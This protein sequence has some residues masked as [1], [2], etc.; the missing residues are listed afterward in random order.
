M[1]RTCGRIP[2]P[3]RLDHLGVALVA[4][5][6]VF[7]SG[8]G[9]RHRESPDAGT[10]ASS[11]LVLAPGMAS[12]GILHQWNFDEARDWHDSPFGPLEKAPAKVLDLAGGWDLT[13]VGLTAT[14]WVSGREFMAVQMPGGAAHLDAGRDLA[15]EL[16]GTASLAFWIRTTQK[17]GL[18][19]WEAPG[20]AGAANERHRDGIQWGW[21]DREGRLIL[22]ADKDTLACTPT[23]VSDGAWHFVVL[24]RDA[25]TGAGQVYL[26]GARV[27]SRTGPKG[28]R[29]LAFR[30]LGQIEGV[31][32]A[33]GALSG[34]LDKVTVFNRVLP[35]GEVNSFMANHAPKAWDCATEISSDRPCVT[36]SVLAQAY[37]AENDA[38]A[39]RAWTQPA[40]GTATHNG[41]GSF[42]YSAAPGFAGE[43]RF[44]VVIQD[45]QG[46]FHQAALKVTVVNETSGGCVPTV[47][48]VGLAELTAGGSVI[49]QPGWRVPRIADW[50]GDGKPDLLVGAGGH[51]WF[52]RNTGTSAVHSFAAGVKVQAAGADV[53]SGDGICPIALADMT[54][55]GVSDLIVSDAARKLQVYGNTAHKGQ[56]VALAAPVAVKQ[57]DG[58]DLVLP[59]RRFDIGD[60][61]GDGKPD[62]I[63][64]AGSGDVRLFIGEG[65]AAPRYSDSRVLFSGSYNLYPR[66]CDLNGNGQADLV[67][68]VNWGG[69]AYWLDVGVQGLAKAGDLAIANAAG[70][71]DSLRSADGAAVD[72][73]DLDGDGVPDLVAGGHA[74][75]RIQIACGRRRTVLDYLVRIEAI[76]N[77]HPDDLGTALSADD[78]ALLGKIDEANRGIVSLIQN[79]SPA[80]REAVYTALA[81][82]VRKYP[83][84]KYQKLDAKKFHHVPGIVLQNWVLLTHARPDTAVHRRDVAEVMGLTGIVRDI[85]LESSLALG[86][87]G[88]LD[89]AQLGSVR[90]MM[91]HQPRPLFPDS[92]ITFDQLFGDGR[93]GFI[94]TPDSTKNTFG[95]G[96]GMANEWAR[97]LTEAIE[98]ASGKGAADG[99][100]FTFVMGHEVTHSMDGYVSSRANKDLRRRWGHMLCHAAGPDVVAGSNGWMDWEATKKHFQ[101]AGF[102]SPP[103]QT[104]EQAW[105]TYWE[106]G[107]GSKFRHTS[108]MRGGI[109]WFL[110]S[111]QESLA[112]QANHHWASG[113]GRLVGALAR[114]RRGVA[115]GNLPEKANMTEVVDFIDYLSVGMNRVALPKTT[116][117]TAPEKRV[118][119][120]IHLADLERDDL[121]RITRL[122]VDG[123][124]FELK[125]DAGGTVT[126]VRHASVPR[127]S[128]TSRA[129]SRGWVT[130]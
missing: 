111:P 7:G 84:L 2:S 57:P 45:G 122:A 9:C 92:V 62:L 115:T 71:P 42:T 125:L 41:D 66:F 87:N 5:V 21:L 25:A 51:V 56:A 94:W 65:S 91:R 85:Y 17:G 19:A 78:N 23:P 110:G 12:D 68:G 80:T 86:D 72:L 48:F 120:T 82:H 40:H 46:G 11:A 24:T 53:R 113:P 93:G 59:D 97:D 109:D 83:F 98:A 88:T 43:D 89:A 8:L 102:F 75:D 117:V 103:G 16:G 107:P 119:W 105:K 29:K 70:K 81:A 76:Y 14:N 15:P 77:A 49:S 108:F 26:D 54:G 90:D 31:A 63:T 10:P 61:N 39:V 18:N 104:W 74:G 73:A 60:W 44:R 58:G 124:T 101:D 129:D 67:R 22:S 20:I 116:T 55:D 35:A 50:D 128:S 96:V 34:R 13:P 64:G 130:P 52:Y 28:K 37:D 123:D 95:C 32:G 99:D 126:D 118:D 127:A 121:G 33:V 47:Q 4:S 3:R 114:F 38:L 1:G 27:D 36:E 30:S 79:G 69:V 112:T 106:T 100:Y 6:V